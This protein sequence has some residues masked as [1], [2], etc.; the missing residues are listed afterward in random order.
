MKRTINKIAKSFVDNLRMKKKANESFLMTMI[1]H[2]GFWLF[3]LGIL[4]IPQVASTLKV[5]NENNHQYEDPWFAWCYAIG[6]DFAILIFSVMGKTK[7]AIAYLIVMI[8]HGLMGQYFPGGHEW[9]KLLI[10]LALPITIFTFTHLFYAKK[11]EQEESKVQMT[12]ELAQISAI[13]AQGI[14]ME[15]LPYECP[16]CNVAKATAKELNGHVSGHKQAKVKEWFPEEYGDWQ[17]ENELRASKLF[18]I[19]NQSES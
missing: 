18:T 9:G 17:K 12:A 14:R 19:Q 6:L 4:L 3:S 13:L 5:Y 10:N 16:Q 2:E 8:L 7:I 1:K 11:K 15:A